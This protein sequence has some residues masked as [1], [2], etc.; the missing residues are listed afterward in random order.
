MLEL[1]QPNP[2]IKHLRFV[3]LIDFRW[4]A[5]DIRIDS[6]EAV[7]LYE[8][9][10]R[11]SDA[12]TLKQ[13]RLASL[14]PFLSM[15]PSLRNLRFSGLGLLTDENDAPPPIAPDSSSTFIQQERR[16]ASLLASLRDTRVEEDGRRDGLR[17]HITPPPFLQ[18]LV[19][20]GASGLSADQE[21]RCRVWRRKRAITKRAEVAGPRFVCETRSDS[22]ARLRVSQ[23]EC[24]MRTT[25][26]S[27]CSRR[28]VGKSRSASEC[29]RRSGGQ[30][31]GGS[32]GALLSF[33]TLL[34]IG[35]AI[36]RTPELIVV[37]VS[38]SMLATAAWR[39]ERAKSWPN[40][41]LAL[42]PSC[43][44]LA[45]AQSRVQV[46]VQALAASA[47]PPDQPQQPTMSSETVAPLDPLPP[48]TDPSRA[49]RFLDLPEE[50]IRRIF[51]TVFDELLAERIPGQYENDPFPSHLRF[52]KQRPPRQ[53]SRQQVP[54]NSGLYKLVRP[55]WDG[56]LALEASEGRAFD[57]P[58]PTLSKRIR[59]LDLVEDKWFDSI[60]LYGEIP[61][62]L[63]AWERARPSFDFLT[64]FS[65]LTTLRATFTRGIPRTFTDALSH[66]PCL[67]DLTLQFPGGLD[68]VFFT[69]GEKTPVLRRLTLAAE[70]AG[71]E[72]L[73][74]LLTNLPS[75]LEE[76]HI[77]Y[78]YP[79]GLPI[80]W[81]TVPRLHLY[82]PKGYFRDPSCVIQAF[83]KVFSLENPRKVVVQELTIQVETISLSKSK[84]RDTVYYEQVIPALLEFMQSTA[85]IKHLRFFGFVDLRWWKNDIR[86][87]S[88]ESLTLHE[89][90]SGTDYS[91][92]PE[93]KN[94]SA[95]PHFLSMFPSLRKLNLSGV[96]LLSDTDESLALDSCSFSTSASPSV[97]PDSRLHLSAPLAAL[98]EPLLSLLP[99]S[100]SNLLSSSI[101][102]LARP[103]QSRRFGTAR[104]LRASGR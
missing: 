100:L 44:S 63:T 95:L 18:I 52:E 33:H 98:Q 91:E 45:V 55:V 35:E 41:R 19:E 64:T 5:S 84:K 49:T 72:D 40:L 67:S 48:V 53:L 11:T 7:T 70:V 68:D 74:A 16:L 71:D 34:E 99:P 15:F 92:S 9:P 85:S 76:V 50:L 79:A 27:M 4:W 13:G 26:S 14:Q 32:A 17:T 89:H 57:E 37:L 56:Y 51:E 104:T 96:G 73:H 3:N 82:P 54:I 87:D 28:V 20:T 47:Q 29:R 90:P 101:A 83:E 6:V 42:L 10:S 94:L 31:V 88:I 38:L 12:P 58:L 80:P 30:A 81:Y 93:R 59:F 61:H 77:Y 103:T 78:T 21:S 69:L 25:G 39:G 102:L 66:L 24:R 22:T 60:R 36:Q 65:R 86:I 62:S 8:H 97:Q 46:V 1:M 23:L 2:S 43:T 75:T